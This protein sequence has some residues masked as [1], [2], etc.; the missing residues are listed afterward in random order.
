M[1]EGPTRITSIGNIPLHADEV[2]VWQASLDADPAAV[3]RFFGYLSPVEKERAARFLSPR[4]GNRFAVCRGILREL[5][6]GYL[7]CPA[8]EVRLE[9]GPRGK[10][11]LHSDAGKPDLDLRFNVSNSQGIALYAFALGREVGI[12]IEKISPEVAFEG[13][14][15]RYFSPR[16]Q[17]EL[18]NLP[19]KVRPEGFFLCWTRKEAYIKA[20]GDGLYLPLD[21]FDVSL[22]PG[23]PAVL[24]SQD[25]DRWSL[26]SLQ[27]RADFAGSLV[28]EGGEI[29]VKLWGVPGYALETLKISDQRLPE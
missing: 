14:E 15:N 24:N 16:E 13:I 27:P 22:T 23:E 18:R 29:P 28:V 11:A 12:D 7:R 21:S 19:E 4:D 1:S 25:R 5:L 26:Y 20:R 9:A 8:S 17:Q 2:H 10:P 3:E 6:G